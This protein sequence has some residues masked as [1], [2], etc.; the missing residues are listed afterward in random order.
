MRIAASARQD[1]AAVGRRAATW[2]PAMRGGHR[3]SAP[4]NSHRR[5]TATWGE[6]RAGATIH[7]PPHPAGGP[8]A[9]RTLIQ[10][11]GCGHREG[12]SPRRVAGWPRATVAAALIGG[13]DPREPGRRHAPRP[14][15]SLWR[16]Q[17]AASHRRRR[18][19]ATAPNP[20]ARH[21]LRRRSSSSTRSIPPRS[22]YG[23]IGH[24]PSRTSPAPN[25]GPH[26]DGPSAWRPRRGV[27]CAARDRPLRFR[28]A[29]PLARPRPRR[30]RP[31]PPRSAHIPRRRSLAAPAPGRRASPTH[32]GASRSLPS[33]AG[34]EVGSW[35][36]CRT[37]A[38][39][40]GRRGRSAGR[41]GRARQIGKAT[42][43]TWRNVPCASERQTARRSARRMN[44]S[45][46]GV[47][48]DP[49]ADEGPDAG[50]PR[51]RRPGEHDA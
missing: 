16:V 21:E 44:G 49:L 31:V 40:R 5:A 24:A 8:V 35:P 20:G 41:R 12:R 48:V 50:S 29:R 6:R 14:S 43:L 3:P 46:G 30:W 45:S 22:G 25:D 34:A 13:Q 47:A 15:A 36:T 26:R 4:I 37:A 10:R 9:G 1:E 27:A 23:R 17:A 28:E 18:R 51:G 2:Q 42:Q 11:G 7:R 39:R 19:I 38:A 32:S 33:A